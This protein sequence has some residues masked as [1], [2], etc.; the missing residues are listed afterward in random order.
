M[1]AELGLSCSMQT[2]SCGMKTLSCGMHA[3]CSSPTRDQTGPPALGAWS[4]AHWTTREVP[5]TTVHL[6]KN[7]EMNLT[8]GTH[9]PSLCLKYFQ[10]EF[11]YLSGGKR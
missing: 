2:L 10:V 8:G 1:H 7:T 6:R 4:L 11:S 5:Y 3:G 9:F